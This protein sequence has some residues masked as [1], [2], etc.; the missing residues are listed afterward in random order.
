V[1]SFYPKVGRARHVAVPRVRAVVRAAQ[2]D[3]ALVRV[4]LRVVARRRK[5]EDKGIGDTLS[6]MMG[7]PG[8]AFKVWFHAVFGRSCGC[9]TRTAWLNRRYPYGPD[10]IIFGPK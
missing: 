6:R 2:R 9:D 3:P 10:G 1:I 8:E 7:G 4:A 5:P